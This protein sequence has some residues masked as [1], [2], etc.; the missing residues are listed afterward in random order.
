MAGGSGLRSRGRAGRA[1]ARGAAAGRAAR[2][3]RPGRSHRHA[4]GRGLR[5]RLLLVRTRRRQRRIEHKVGFDTTE[6]L[7][8][9]ADV[10]ALRVGQDE[11]RA[12][13]AHRG[14][15]AV[16]RPRPPAALGRRA[17]RP[18]GAC[19]SDRIALPDVEQGDAQAG[20]RRAGC[21][22]A[23]RCQAT[24]IGTAAAAHAR[25]S[26]R[27][28][29]GSRLSR[30]IPTGAARSRDAAT[31]EATRA[32]GR[33]ATSRAQAAMYA[34]SQPFSHASASDADGGPARAARRRGRAP[35][36]ARQPR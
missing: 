24:R 33:P 4:A 21:S 9:A 25:A 29:G 11:R 22:P 14:V 1:R 18:A 28:Q 8:R 15:A 2:R 17:L 34:A 26:E 27:R 36:A 12:D 23:R 35:A 6:H 30:T 10:V 3:C 19:R 31:P 20:R 32:C 7:L 16:R 5:E 13:A